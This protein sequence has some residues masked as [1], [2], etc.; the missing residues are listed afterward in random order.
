MDGV[1][2]FLRRTKYCRKLRYDLGEESAFVVLHKIAAMFP[3]YQF[4]PSLREFTMV[5]ST[6]RPRFRTQENDEIISTF[7]NLPRVKTM[8]VRRNGADWTPRMFPTF[9]F[10]NTQQFWMEMEL[11]K[12]IVVSSKPRQ[13]VYDSDVCCTSSPLANIGK[14]FPISPN[15]VE[16]FR[17]AR[18]SEAESIVL[19]SAPESW[20]LLAECTTVR[21][22]QISS[23]G[24]SG[25]TL[26]G[27]PFV[28]PSADHP[29]PSV[30]NL[31]W[32]GVGDSMTHII[33]C[34]RS[35]IFPALRTLAM[36]AVPTCGYEV[37]AR[38]LEI[39]PSVPELQSFTLVNNHER[40]PP[41]QPGTII[42]P[43]WKLLTCPK[44]EYL[45]ISATGTV[46]FR[47]SAQTLVI[48][49]QNW[50]KLRHLHVNPS[51]PLNSPSQEALEG[52]VSLA[53]QCTHLEY[54]AVGLPSVAAFSQ[55][56]PRTNEDSGGAFGS[57][58]ETDSGP[59]A[60]RAGSKVKYLDLGTPDMS[61]VP[62]FGNPT[63]QHQQVEEYAVYIH[64]LFPFVEHFEASSRWYGDPPQLSEN[65]ASA[66]RE[67]I[68][69]YESIK[70]SKPQ[71]G[72]HA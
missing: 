35:P 62:A 24:L 59:K 13:F 49:A 29:W 57:N 64:G 23:S 48:M 40:E 7:P 41:Y 25:M 52:V 43:R 28:R 15:V 4:L 60:R 58:E 38:V 6:N 8:V 10:W 19:P 34:V 17:L 36:R 26:R 21:T 3:Q 12:K 47:M 53:S 11:V 68:K 54:L 5:L 45:H 31:V 32:R 63:V 14:Y 39:G 33:D 22:V 71:R 37:L 9:A 27:P 42:D 16:Y 66:W 2:L 67:V 50:P 56:T 70:R 65:A 20:R 72:F 46:G 44:I 69:A 1:K 61:Q 51:A 30:H 18:E 55:I